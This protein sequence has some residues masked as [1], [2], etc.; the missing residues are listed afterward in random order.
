MAEARPGAE[1]ED[2]LVSA[3]SMRCTQFCVVALHEMDALE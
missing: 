2:Y 3:S 1:L